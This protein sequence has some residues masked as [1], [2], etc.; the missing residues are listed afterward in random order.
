[1]KKIIAAGLMA[2]AALVSAGTAHA[3]DVPY[4]E[5]MRGLCHQLDPRRSTR[6]DDLQLIGGSVRGTN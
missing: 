6:V 2:A 3:D 5:F 4:G 1:M